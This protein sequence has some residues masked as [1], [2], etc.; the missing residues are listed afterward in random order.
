MNRYPLWK[1]LMILAVILIAALYALPNIY[2]QDPSIEVT[3]LA[4]NAAITDGSLTQ[5]EAALREQEL[6][7]KRIDKEADRLRIRFNSGES[8]LL[9]MEHLQKQLGAEY[10]FAMNLVADVPG[11]LTA[12]NG[13]P[14][15]LGLDLRG[16][17]YV[18]L[19]VDM[20][21]AI[22]KRMESYQQDIDDRLGDARIR[23]RV[24]LPDY[25]DVEDP[26]DL[27]ITVRI[28]DAAD[29]D[30][31]RAALLGSIDEI[32]AVEDGHRHPLYGPMRAV[33][34]RNLARHHLAQAG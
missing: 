9:A 12:I 14:M 23:H 31:A 21:T 13:N 16:G 29:L 10:A 5:V 3:T 30:A 24:D 28:A 7:F 22:G 26:A 15:S 11:W 25:D 34:V 8:Q 17:I 2:G 18:L 32:A 1:N 33:D 27:T 4:K 6:G 20:A 19:E